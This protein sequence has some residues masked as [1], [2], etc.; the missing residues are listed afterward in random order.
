MKNKGKIK[1]FNI[2]KGFGYITGQNGK[3]YFL[4]KSECTSP[5]S[6][7]ENDAVEFNVCITPKGDK[8]INVVKLPKALQGPLRQPVISNSANS[9]PP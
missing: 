8:A 9:S 2:E 6:L 3:D 1:W 7:K 5:Q 4:H